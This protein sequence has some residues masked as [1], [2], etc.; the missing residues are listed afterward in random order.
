VLD[1]LLATLVLEVDVDV[2][3]FVAL[4]AHEALEQ[5][6]DAVGI[7]GRD[8]E[9]KAHGAV[10]RSPPPLAE[11]AARACE[12]DDLVHRQEVRRIAE[13]RDDGELVL[14]LARH[15][16]RNAARVALAGALPGEGAE[17]LHRRPSLRGELGGNDLVGV[18]VSQRIER[19]IGRAIQ[20]APCRL[21][22]LGTVA[23]AQDDVL[24]PL[25]PALGIGRDEMPRPLD[26]N[27]RLDAGERIEQPAP[28]S[29]VHADIVHRGGRNIERICQRA[30]SLGQRGALHVIDAR[31]RDREAA[32]AATTAAPTHDARKRFCRFEEI[33]ISHGG[34]GR[35][36]RHEH[37]QKPAAA[38]M[39]AQQFHELMHEADS[40]HERTGS[41]LQR[42]G[43][44]GC[45][46]ALHPRRTRCLVGH[47]MAE[48]G[49]EKRP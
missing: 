4:P 30:G 1:D 13:V 27:A 21:Q 35:R 23:V 18:L 17:I 42:I 10:G 2:G 25:Q 16:L 46:A 5:D 36:R 47:A 3:W 22:R 33:P 45:L 9:C 32:I 24:D 8:A 49:A 38:R 34:V 28:G 37:A 31:H 39:V 48:H 43:A 20:E 19:E 44:A 6:I 12:R 40:R 29:M 41:L 11:D 15:L 26:G 14:D 7:D